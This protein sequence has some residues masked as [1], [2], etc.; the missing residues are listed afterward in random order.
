MLGRTMRCPNPTCR[1][2][3]TVR[4]EQEQLSLGDDLPAAVPVPAPGIPP[5]TQRGGAVGEMVPM[6]PAEIDP[7]FELPSEMLRDFDMGIPEPKSAQGVSVTASESLP[8]LEPL[9]ALPID[10]SSSSSQHSGNGLMVPLVEAELA[11]E[12]PA[13][14]TRADKVKPPKRK[15]KRTAK[16]VDWQT[17]APPPVRGVSTVGDE[18]DLI[19]EADVAPAVPVLAEPEPEPVLFFPKRKKKRKVASA[20]VLAGLTVFVV[21]G[22]VSGILL[23]RNYEANRQTKRADE[24][25]KEYESG[26]FVQAAKS[27]EDMLKDYADEPR[28]D[29]YKFMVAWCN[30]RQ[31]AYSVSSA[32]EVP[33]TWQKVKQFLDER[34]DDPFLKDYA[35][36]AADTVRKVAETAAER[37]DSVV[38]K[39]Q[40]DEAEE[41]VRVG[42]EALAYFPRYRNEGLGAGEERVIEQLG[43][44]E[45]RVRG[46]RDRQRVVDEITKGLEDPTE[47]NILK[48]EETA[49]TA[50]LSGDPEVKE[51]LAKA[52]RESAR[53]IKFEAAD[54]ELAKSKPAPPGLPG[55][56][57]T[58][59]VGRAPS[60]APGKSGVVFAQA[61]GVLYAHDDVTGDLLWA[62]RVGLDAAPPLPPA[63]GSSD[64]ALV[65]GADGRSVSARA[66]RTGD[67]LW[68][69]PLEAMCAGR[70]VVAGGRAF[71]PLRD[72]KEG[73]PG[74]LVAFDIASGNRLGTLICGRPLAGSGARQ[75]GSGRL[76]FPAAERLIFVVNPDAIDSPN[77]CEAVLQTDHPAGSLRGDPILL[78]GDAPPVAGGEDPKF[79]VLAQADGIGYTKVRAFKLDAGPIAALAPAPPVE[80]S[81]RG[82]A[83]YTPYFDGERLAVAT[84]AGELGIYGI[85]L[86][87]NRDKMLFELPPKRFSLPPGD[88]VAPGQVVYA[89]PYD[90]WL[91]ARG[92]L[93]HL[94]LGVSDSE[95]QKLVMAPPSLAVGVPLHPA[96]LTPRRDLAVIVAQEPGAGTCRVV[97]ID[98]STGDVRWQRQLGAVPPEDPVVVGGKVFFM[99]R[100]GGF[101]RIDPEQV[102]NRPDGGEKADDRIS[103]AAPDSDITGT[104]ALA[105]APDGKS[106]A[107]LYATGTGRERRLIVK[108]FREG[109]TVVTRTAPLSSELAGTPALIGGAVVLATADGKLRRLELAP[110]MALLEIGPTWR[111]ANAPA[112]AVCHMLPLTADEFVVTDGLN[113]MARLRWKSADAIEKVAM[114]AL[115]KPIAGVCA[116]PEGDGLAVALGSQ[117]D[118]FDPDRF[119]VVK[120][121]PLA[122][123]GELRHGVTAGP[124]VFREGTGPVRI[125]CV[126]D[127]NRFC[128]FDAKAEKPAVVSYRCTRDEITGLP[129]LSGGRF[130][131]ADRSGAV[132]PVD[133]ESGKEVGSAAKVDP[134]SSV[135][136]A[137]PAAFGP[138]RLLVPLSD[139]TA[140]LLPNGSPH[141][142]PKAAT[143]D[144]PG[145][146]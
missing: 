66:V 77:P 38:Q 96:V 140:V 114:K 47:K 82:W 86:P 18:N 137:G 57:L 35:V 85:N 125:G 92:E 59:R 122:A 109:Q 11:P 20:A 65:V 14:E 84:D 101:Y 13:P 60:A 51:L 69:H 104:P 55:V 90:C 25:R 68:Y 37:G 8:S 107:V 134:A 99:D 54:A 45:L 141:A 73:R 145:S 44:I 144:Q 50:G 115:A 143:A 30:V 129:A 43:A 7:D 132:Q 113:S 17:A 94:R 39:K 102:A 4:E 23:W 29:E 81:L 10:E 95:G 31:A 22:S 127:G 88:S 2:V 27:Y 124:R 42:R 116:L 26:K 119:M 64:P 40:Y 87:G 93:I 89:D 52:R 34:V 15:E 80:S 117:V 106:G 72:D 58:P 24:A 131:V 19:I 56:L 78:G 111:A 6:L 110:E 75:P 28:A 9:D 138:D 130:F 3:F 136:A 142:P 48:A 41:S 83:W 12:P 79:L 112:K 91:L 135:P 62:T 120:S 16:A 123:A 71:I 108:L 121:V 139:G 36:D 61:R 97:A 46:A 98:L 53:T 146:P 1:E 32:S 70:P 118:L 103:L 126:A 76:F 33:A 105:A 63:P 74:R 67:V 5:P 21:V 49:V 100:A 133:P 128:W